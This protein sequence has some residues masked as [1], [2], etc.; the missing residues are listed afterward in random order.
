MTEDLEESMRAGPAESRPGREHA[1][2]KKD[3][4]R[5]PLENVGRL[6]IDRVVPDPA[7]PRVAFSEDALNRLAASIRERGQ[8]S[9]IRVRWSDDLGRWLIVSGERRWRAARRAGLAEVECYFDE[10]G[11]NHSEVL[12]Q[13]LVEN[14]LREDLRPVEE[15]HAFATLMRLNGWSGK[16]VAQALHIHPSRVSRAL[17][18]MRLPESVQEQV[19]AG[20]IPARAAYEISKLPDHAVQAALAGR[21]A[22]GGLSHDEAARAVRRLRGRPGNQPRATK[23]TF[24][25]DNDWKVVVSAPRKGTYYEIE[26]ALSLALEEVRHRIDSG[27]QLF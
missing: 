8:L 24:F 20:A 1:P 27:C 22:G 4:G 10:A 15:A 17:A 5:R 26:Q 7:Q 16:D 9:P 21:A 2:A 13:Q 14:C 25:G 12:Q 11:L 6:A 19:N 23:Q 3:A 18:L